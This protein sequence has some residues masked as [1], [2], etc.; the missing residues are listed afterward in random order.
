M[1]EHNRDAEIGARVAGGATYSAVGKEF[2]LSRERV[3]Q[4][5]SRLGVIRPIK[6]QTARLEALIASGALAIEGDKRRSLAKTDISLDRL[7]ELLSYDPATGIWTWKRARGKGKGVAGSVS[8]Q[9][10]VQIRIDRRLYMAH[11]LAWFYVHRIWPEAGIDHENTV[12][13]DNRI[14]NLRLGS[15]VENM[16]NRKKMAHNTSGHK[17]VWFDRRTGKWAAEIAHIHLGQFDSRDQ[18]AAAYLTAAQV[19]YGEFARV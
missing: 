9:G 4:I 16:G 5:V 10:Y 3:R 8:D 6:S 17:G 19:R 18:A 15:Q 12:R 11:V 2:S 13:S 7:R 14:D 1:T